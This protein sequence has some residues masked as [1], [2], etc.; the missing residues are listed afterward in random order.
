MPVEVGDYCFIGTGVVLL[1]GAKIPHNSI[2]AAGAVLGEAFSIEGGLYGGVPAKK[3][4][5]LD[6][7]E[8]AYMKRTDG[9]IW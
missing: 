1:P 8:Y 3:I 4:K 2:L 7:E 6:L 5:D 9:Y